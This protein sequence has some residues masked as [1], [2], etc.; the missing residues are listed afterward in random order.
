M[1]RVISN[2]GESIYEWMFTKP[3]QNKMTALAKLAAALFGTATM[4]NG[5]SCVPTGP[6]SMQV[7]INPGEIYSQANLEASLCGTLPA[8]TTHQIL[9]QG[10]LLDAYTT[11][12]GAL[13]APGTAGQSVNYLIE[14]QYADSDVSID[15]TTG[16]TP[17]VLQFYNA[18]NPAQPYS[19]PNN[20]GQTST[21]FRK[22]IVSLQ[23][24]AGAAATTGSQTTPAPDAGWTGL[25]VVTVANGQ[26]TVTAGNITQYASAPILPS[27]LLHAVQASSL[28]VGTDTGA[29]NACVVNY[30]YPVTALKD[31]MVLWFKAA[32]ANTGATTLNVNGLGAQPVVG[33]NHSAL[34]GGEIVLNGK[35]QV[36]WNATISSFVLIECTGAAVQVGAAT[37]SRHA[38]QL[39]QATG[40]LLN[41][42]VFTS[43]GT[44]NATAGTNTAIV[45]V[46]GGGGGS[47]G[48]SATGAGQISVTGGGGAGAYARTRI[49][50]GF[51]GTAVTVGAGG[52]AGAAN[53]GAGGGG[54]TS[55]FG[56]F[57]SAVGGG[58]SLGKG[59]FA[60]GYISIGGGGG[61][62][63]T[64][65]NI[66]NGRGS[67]GTTGV[68][69][70]T[71]DFVSGTGGATPFGAG[72]TAV[73]ATA[74]GQNGATYG[75]GAGGA[76]TAHSAAAQA[77]G[78]GAPGVVIVYEYA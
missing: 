78:V 27:D 71:G 74:A 33:G 66:T 70:G 11:A 55:S 57:V 12:A 10:I 1:D 63:P 39:G 41:V 16:N 47:G 26:S 15:P 8:D 56:A 69:I 28:T 73:N 31:G 45:E 54:G 50:A 3:D 23:V 76:C 9:K 40:R 38:M 6:A 59:A 37:Q 2:V 22:G 48:T 77:G 21:T 43:S 62:I 5:L 51:S 13:A 24:K 42:Q 44:Y 53:A 64:T 4:V 7:V 49:T 58:G 18:S 72:G 52:T 46:V 67:D 60:P 25:W 34:Q 61:T 32:A 20:N 36:V 30:S 29:A 65:G 19:G 14:A 75:S 35:C 17:V 68:V